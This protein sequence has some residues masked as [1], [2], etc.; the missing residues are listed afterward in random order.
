MS[1]IIS[2][3][4]GYAVFKSAAFTLKT[5][6]IN[7]SIG[8]VLFSFKSYPFLQKK[9]DTQSISEIESGTN[10][11]LSFEKEEAQSVDCFYKRLSVKS[12]YKYKWPLHTLE[13]NKIN[14]GIDQTNVTVPEETINIY[15]INLGTDAAPINV[16]DVRIK[17]SVV[18]IGLEVVPE[19]PF[20]SIAYSTLE[21]DTINSL[22]NNVA[23]F[24]AET[25]V[26]FTYTQPLAPVTTVGYR[27]Y[28]TFE[29][30]LIGTKTTGGVKAENIVATGVTVYSVDG[31][32]F[33]SHNY[34]SAAFSLITEKSW[35]SVIWDN[36]TIPEV[37]QSTSNPFGSYW[38]TLKT[39]LQ[40]II[41]EANDLPTVGTNTGSALLND[42]IRDVIYKGDIETVT[43]EMAFRLPF[44][45]LNKKNT[46]YVNNNNP[47]YTKFDTWFGYANAVR[48]AAGLTGNDNLSRTGLKKGFTNLVQVSSDHLSLYQMLGIRRNTSFTNLN[49][50]SYMA[51]IM[52]DENPNST[53]LSKHKDIVHFPSNYTQT[54]TTYSIPTQGADLNAVLTYMVTNNV[55]TAADKTF[56][57]TSAINS[58][59]VRKSASSANGYYVV[60]ESATLLS[61]IVVSGSNNSGLTI[62]MG[63]DMGQQS[64]EA[65]FYTY[66][67]FVLTAG[68]VDA[69]LYTEALGKSGNQAA[70]LYEA[71]KDTIIPTHTL[72]YDVAVEHTVPLMEDKFLEPSLIKFIRGGTGHVISAA[73]KV[74]KVFQED[75]NGAFFNGN[76]IQYM[77]EFEKMLYLSQIYNAGVNSITMETSAPNNTKNRSRYF[78]HAI[79]THDYRWLKYFTQK[80]KVEGLST[81][82]QRKTALQDIMKV[83]RIFD[84]YNITQSS[85]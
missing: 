36:Q 55:I 59:K 19:V 8:Q 3:Y 17:D 80:P 48:D 60:K 64:D 13:T 29:L 28:F 45:I 40:S 62:G 12:K 6:I 7:D 21:K 25:P 2:E 31:Y 84:H 72:S 58:F 49:V 33:F 14:K 16:L 18:L 34:A 23:N 67:G 66:T 35:N 50:P 4:N 79:N 68:S 53:Y 69:L 32:N 52:E 51:K 37:S 85:L 63:Y 73:N 10:E 81:Y 75:A 26:F 74:L 70:S 11:L 61:C 1:E 9:T 20:F 42:E 24:D 22:I 56:F 15:K 77:N 46:P 5:G 82:P 41:N 27:N 30:K 57:L 78:A 43:F 83:K 39:N 71:F 76:A 44:F 65:Y 54:K 47:Y 38:S